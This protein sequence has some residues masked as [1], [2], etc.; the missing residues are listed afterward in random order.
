[1]ENTLYNQYA[2]SIIQYIQLSETWNKLYILISPTTVYLA[3]TLLASC[4]LA[5][6]APISTAN[7]TRQDLC[8]T[9]TVVG[10]AISAFS[11][12]R[13]YGFLLAGGSFVRKTVHIIDDERLNGH[14][15]LTFLIILTQ[16]VLKPIFSL[17]N[18]DICL[19]LSTALLIDG[20]GLSYRILLI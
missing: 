15:C 13:A 9:A 3:F 11:C 12:W 10:V 19:A 14:N 16:T 20:F 6:L 2:V 7:V 17:G 18:A 8:A 4:Y 5:P 1:M